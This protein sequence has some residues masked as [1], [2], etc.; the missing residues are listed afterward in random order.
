LPAKITPDKVEMVVRLRENGHT[1][2]SA[3]RL[4]NVSTSYIR[5]LETG[6]DNNGQGWRE[7]RKIKQIRGPIPYKDL[8]PE[9]KRAWDDIAYFARRYFG[10]VVMPYQVEAVGKIQEWLASDREEYV[11][12]NQPPGTGKSTFYTRVLPAWLT[13]RDRTLRGMIVS[14]AQTTADTYLIALRRR[15]EEPARLRASPSDLRAGIAV[16]A[17]ASIIE[18]FGLFKAPGADSGDKWSMKAFQV[19]QMPGYPPGD[20]EHTWQAFGQGG[21]FMGTR[22]DIIVADDVYDPTAIQTAEARQKIR[23]WFKESV[24]SRLEPGG[25]LLL[26]GQ[27]LHADDIYR[28]AIDKKQLVDE[29]DEEIE[30]PALRPPMYHHV[31]YKAHYDELCVGDHGKDAKPWPEGCM[32]YPPRVS[33]RKMTSIMNDPDGGKQTFAVQYQQEDSVPG[34]TLVDWLWVKGGRDDDG[35]EYLGCYNKDR[36]LWELPPGLG[37]DGVMW[38]A[39][40]PSPSKWWSIQCL[41][42]WTRVTTDRGEVP[43][44]QVRL[45]D[46]V[47]TRKG[48]APVQH[49]TMMGRKPT[50]N[51]RLSNG[52]TLTCTADHRIAT[53]SGWVEAGRLALGVRLA[54]GDLLARTAAATRTLPVAAEQVFAGVG[55]PLGAVGL[56]ASLKSGTGQAGVLGAA[57]FPQVLRVDARRVV[58]DVVDGFLGDG[59]SGVDA[60]GEPVGEAFA[61][62]SVD[63]PVS[64]G[65]SASSPVPAPRRGDHDPAS[66]VRSVVGNL[67]GS[68]DGPVP[69]GHT[70]CGRG[71]DGGSASA[72]VHVVSIDAGSTIDTWDIG[73]PVEH[74][75]E[76][77]GVIVHNCWWYDKASE[78]R[79]LLDHYRAK[80]GADELL[81]YDPL[82][83]HFSGIMDVWQKKSMA[84][85]RPIRKWIV[86]QNA[87]QRFLLQS[88]PADLWKT[89]MGVNILK[90]E[91]HG[92]KS[93][94]QLGVQAAIPS[95]WRLGRIDLPMKG[96]DAVVASKALVDEVTSWPGGATDDAVMAH[97]FGEWNLKR[98]YV[99]QQIEPLGF[100]VPTWM[101]PQPAERPT[102]RRV[103]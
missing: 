8:C 35:T 75:F 39:A 30:D 77:E 34:S 50:L 16:D 80:M 45:T 15:L 40:D 10:L 11:V 63:A 14:N 94:P 81:D 62:R 96:H 33:W 26:V 3:A 88:R 46:R 48:W 20:K 22:L 65:V 66:D 42:G 23:T 101:S 100:K 98:V 27:R 99:P 44:S 47:L 32:L 43:I 61:A 13:I 38:A 83:G 29:N 55:V 72:S 64:E 19:M 90:H 84:L 12:I 70:A 5:K 41:A 87:A 18:D 37:S 91:T 76:A 49:V 85:G 52:R 24:E 78:R 28:Y 9:A 56:G 53:E 93:D 82:T 4:A 68:G 103:I 60:V 36:G 102:L 69:A 74:E 73:V 57:E 97:W 21:R 1:R 95:L 7:A 59:P 17:E 2:E 31:I 6:F 58:A 51:V 79:F 25:I 86:E 67:P 92:N 54:V 71:G 89:K